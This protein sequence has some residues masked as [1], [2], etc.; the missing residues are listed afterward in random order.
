MVWRTECRTLDEKRKY[1]VRILQVKEWTKYVKR[2]QKAQRKRQKLEAKNVAEELM[3]EMEEEQKKKK[4]L[5]RQFRSNMGPGAPT[6]ETPFE[7]EEDPIEERRVMFGEVSSDSEQD[8]EE[9]EKE[10][11]GYKSDDSVKKARGGDQG[12]ME[13]D[14]DEFMIVLQAIRER[15]KMEADSG[16]PMTGGKMSQTGW[17]VKQNFMKK[18]NAALDEKD[19][20][21]VFNGPLITDDK[22]SDQESDDAEDVVILEYK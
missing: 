20:I 14:E 4:K 19:R 8:P 3:I 2:L 9:E 7:D 6:T 1:L 16:K 12:A 17:K 5:K 11:D 15:K 18:N 21:D 13:E 22:G 10:D